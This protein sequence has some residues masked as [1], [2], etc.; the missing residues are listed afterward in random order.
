MGALSKINRGRARVRDPR[1]AQRVSIGGFASRRARSPN[2]GR[3]KT[4]NAAEPRAHAEEQFHA[5]DQIM[6][7]LRKDGYHCELL[8]EKPDRHN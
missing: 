1:A 4:A 5:V 3:A 7:I 8:Q 2:A 6:E